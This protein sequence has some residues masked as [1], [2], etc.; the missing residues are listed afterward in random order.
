ML[1]RRRAKALTGLRT[2]RYGCENRISRGSCRSS[3]SE[4]PSEAGGA[5]LV[6]RP[7]TGWTQCTRAALTLAVPGQATEGVEGRLSLSTHGDDARLPS[8]A[9]P[10]VV[11]EEEPDQHVDAWVLA[12]Y[13]N[14]LRHVLGLLRVRD[15]EDPVG[16]L[17]LVA[18]LGDPE[19][20][21]RIEPREQREERVDV[22]EGHRCRS[23]RRRRRSLARPA[24]V[25]MVRIDVEAR[26]GLLQG[27]EEDERRDRGT[28]PPRPVVA[29]RRGRAADDLLAL[30]LGRVDA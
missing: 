7:L 20:L 18:V 3:T 2:R 14:G 5:G 9:D 28:R 19:V 15:A 30:D 13:R 12:D 11:A 10:A 24:V 25:R 23:L 16:R 4:G 8:V 21:P 17:G 27:P 1:P 22:P 6:S 26:V 29:T